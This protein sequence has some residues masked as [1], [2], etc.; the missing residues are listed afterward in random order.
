MMDRVRTAI[1]YFDRSSRRM[2]RHIPATFPVVS[3]TTPSM[4]VVAALFGAVAGGGVGD[5]IDGVTGA[6]A[7][8]AMGAA[9]SAIAMRLLGSSTSAYATRTFTWIAIAAALGCGLMA[10]FFFTFS[11]VI[12]ATLAQQPTE[13]GIRVMQTINVAVF[14]PWFGVAFT[15]T[16]ALCVLA[17]NATLPR[18]GETAARRALIGSVLYLTGTLLVT[19]FCNVPRNDALATVSAS[20]PAASSVWSVYLAEWTRWNHVRT[21]A[22]MGA[23]T[24]LTLASAGVTSKRQ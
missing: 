4:F 2:S 15:V 1:V 17:A 23:A 9:V 6:A 16:P 19:V 3:L 8:A 21:I 7:G 13:S 22:A 18:T 14:N 11:V 24:L 5:V 12:M 10:G 20:D